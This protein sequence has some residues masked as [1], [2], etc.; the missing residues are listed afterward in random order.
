MRLLSVNDLI[1]RGML[2]KD[3]HNEGF[4]DVDPDC[5][6]KQYDDGAEHE[7]EW[8]QLLEGDALNLCDVSHDYGEQRFGMDE[9]LFTVFVR[10]VV[11][12]E[13]TT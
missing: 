7:V 12:T 3:Q 8:V 1:D 6:I 9:R 10:K 5:I 2:V 11:D 13:F 4:M